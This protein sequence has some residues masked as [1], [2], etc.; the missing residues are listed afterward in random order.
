MS[1]NSVTL[2]NDLLTTKNLCGL[3]KRGEMTIYLWRRNKNLPFI[4]VGGGTRPLIRFKKK[5]I[6]KWAKQ[7]NKTVHE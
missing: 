1:I 7:N 3:F 2:T 5:D 6:L 4:Q